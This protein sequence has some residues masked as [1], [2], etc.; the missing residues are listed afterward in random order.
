M[1]RPKK[2]KT[3]E[4]ALL[5]PLDQYFVESASSIEEKYGL[6]RVSS[7]LEEDANLKYL[8]VPDLGLQWSLGRK[9]FALG[10]VMQV[11]GSEGS[12]KTSFALWVANICM[13][14][15]GIAAMV[16]TEMASST[17]HMKNYLNSPEKFRIFHADT[18]EDGLK[19]TID[20]LNLFLRIDPHG[21]IPKVLIF[22]SIAGSS[23][24]RTQNDEENFVQARVG[25]SA[26]VIKD[27]TNLIK[28]K[29]KETNTLWIV[30]NQGREIIQTGFGGGL[31]PDIDKMIG[32]GGK[33]IPF[34]ATYW[35][36]LK[37]H[38]ATKE[39]G[40][41]SGFKVKG[42]FKKNKLAEPGRVF[43]FNVK[44]GESFDFVESTTNLL[45]AALPLQ[46]KTD[47]DEPVQKGG[48]LG[49]QAAKG[50][51]FFSEELDI[52]RTEAMKAEEI[53]KLAHSEEYYKRCQQELG[54]PIEDKVA[55]F[56]YEAA[57]NEKSKK[58][59]KT[60]ETRL[61]NV[62][63]PSGIP[64]PSGPNDGG[65]QDDEIEEESSNNNFVQNETGDTTEKS[66]EQ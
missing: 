32:S 31:I 65:Q 44:W 60:D 20:Q 33:A 63:A 24:A 27:A 9:G 48:I 7:A 55:T 39:D 37:R 35:L 14:S 51:T 6:D 16:E 62:L 47:T 8:E 13:K 23:E 25:G 53:Y 12:S 52:D 1:P 58:L 28:C 30:L 5:N 46:E 38:A 22:D 42:V 26:K 49:L 11:M 66:S 64:S 18:I 10:R 3:E 45:A 41:T 21:A 40:A 56:N 4:L 59:K 2:I 61:S 15:G 34:A 29:L 50:G 19:M 36:I 17:R 57:L 54:V 43:Y